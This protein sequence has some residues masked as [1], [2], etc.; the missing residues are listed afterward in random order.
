M[1]R[2]HMVTERLHGAG[3]SDCELGQDIKGGIKAH[4]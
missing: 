1:C 2:W 4:D 3:R